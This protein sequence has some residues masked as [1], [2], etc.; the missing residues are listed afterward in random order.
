[1]AG[2]TYSNDGDVTGF[3]GGSDYW[4]VKLSNSGTIQW[5][6]TMGGTND[7]QAN[8][9]KKTADGG[10]ILAGLSS[11]NDGDVIGLHG[12]N[13]WDSWVV[14]LSSDTLKVSQYNDDEFQIYPN[15]ACDILFFHSTNIITAYKI[16]DLTGKILKEG[17]NINCSFINIANLL[18]GIYFIEA[19]NGDKKYS[20]KFVKE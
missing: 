12:E 7:D 9:I 13:Y 17:T 1:V 14:K 16:T 3:H 5:Q 10:Y 20:G 19:F 15:P 4:I 11:S 6:K 8:S 2:Y 18:K